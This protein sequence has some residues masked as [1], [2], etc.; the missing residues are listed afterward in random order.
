M[1]YQSHDL[2]TQR[3]ADIPSRVHPSYLPSF[4]SCPFPLHEEYQQASALLSLT[5]C[6][7]LGLVEALVD[8]GGALVVIVGQWWSMVVNGLSMLTSSFVSFRPVPIAPLKGHDW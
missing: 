5:V 1:T 4:L 7:Y 8:I 6:G 2:S 3:H